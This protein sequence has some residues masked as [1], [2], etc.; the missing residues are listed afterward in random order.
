MSQRSGQSARA[1]TKGRF[2]PGAERLLQSNKEWVAAVR[3]L[4]QPVLDLDNRLYERIS[5]TALS[6]SAF[7]GSR[8]VQYSSCSR[9]QL[10]V[11]SLSLRPL[12]TRSSQL[13][14]PISSS[15][16]R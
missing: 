3:A 7:G 5:K 12:G 6:K 4:D 15:A 16:P 2:W 1:L 11:P 8:P 13:N 10:M 14:A 9:T